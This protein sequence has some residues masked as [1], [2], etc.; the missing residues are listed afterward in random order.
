MA[1][2]LL[3][4]DLPPGI[5]RNGTDYQ[6]KGRW[7]DSSLVRFFAKTIQPVGGWRVMQN[8]SGANFAALTGVPRG[9][10]SWRGS[11]GQKY[12]AIG[13]TS[14]LYLITNGTLYDI[15]PA[16]FT[17]ASSADSAYVAATGNYGAG[18][19]GVGA[20]GTGSSTSVLVETNNWHLDNFGNFLVAVSTS[21]N[22]LY[23]W[24]GNPAVVAAAVAGT[25]APTTAT[26]VVVTPEGFLVALGWT[27]SAANV[28]GV[29]WPSQRTSSVWTPALTNSAG[30]F[31]LAT[32]GRLMAAKRTRSETLLWTDTDLHVME[33][34]GGSL[35]YRFAQAG[36]HC[37]LIAPRAAVVFDT[38]AMWMGANAFYAYD[39]A[40]RSV[41]SEV[42]DYV[43]SDINMTQ[44]TKIWGT[45][46]AEF[47][48][49][50]WFYPS[51]S[52]S[53]IDRYV[54]FNWRENHWTV[55]KLAR[56]AGIDAGAMEHPVFLTPAGLVIEHE[57]V[58]TRTD[59]GTPYLRSGPV[60][61]GDGE[62]LMSVLRL[63]PDEKTLGDVQATLFGQNYPTDPAN[64]YGPYSLANPTSVRLA[65][66]EVALLLTEV[67]NT[68]WRV[69][70]LRL[71]VKQSSRR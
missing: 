59:G 45:T 26:G 57:T 61:L 52:S 1:D 27:D 34:I 10:H 7:H 12:L 50:W 48:E 56:T 60:E 31:E 30:D 33:Y 69:G 28:R 21:D 39:G 17:P 43:F 3:P 29:V 23:L 47:G 44:A 22:K 20:Y 58:Q 54:V 32:A 66:R 2:T 38:M 18:A 40:V 49:A 36:E 41:P 19:Y 9:V 53:E 65:A 35:V 63:V 55:G 5:F 24:A 68:A 4:L 46:I 64:T 70:T 6:A 13:T 51:G 37:G 16:G 71:G 67:R 8:D 42:S 11:N 62:R 25:G 15:T 14:K